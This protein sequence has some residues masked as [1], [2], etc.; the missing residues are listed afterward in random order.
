MPQVSGLILSNHLILSRFPL[1]EAK[2][3][4][5]HYRQLSSILTDDKFERNMRLVRLQGFRDDEAEQALRSGFGGRLGPAVCGIGAI[6]GV[7]LASPLLLG[8]LALMAIIG[9][10]APNH[11]VEVLYNLLARYRN[12]TE[13]PANTAGRRL[14]CFIGV[15][16]LGG[17]SLAYVTG[18]DTTGAVL[19]LTIGLVAV[20]VAATNI[21]VP[22]I[23]FTLIRGAERTRLRAFFPALF[24]T[25]SCDSTDRS[26][27]STPK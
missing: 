8:A 13:V 22:S 6:V 27:L 11:P 26:K 21:C 12:T 18:S 5:N 14:G 1:D 20:F 9:V 7:L 15:I 16:L 23:V 2:A 25:A 24:G 3:P 10:L 4:M 17:A 19:G